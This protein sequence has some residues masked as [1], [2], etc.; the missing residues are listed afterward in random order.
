MVPRKV[1]A[2]S[3]VR[4]FLDSVGG[5]LGAAR[6]KDMAGEEVNGRSKPLG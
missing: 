2:S 5:G 4:R 1:G 3:P 6:A